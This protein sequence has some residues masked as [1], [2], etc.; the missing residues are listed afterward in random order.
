MVLENKKSRKY[1]LIFDFDFEVKA[2]AGNTHLGGEDFE[3]YLVDHFAQ[4]LKKK[5]IKEQEK[6]IN[7]HYVV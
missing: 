2:T 4:E 1:L 7:V 3:K 6:Q 5:I